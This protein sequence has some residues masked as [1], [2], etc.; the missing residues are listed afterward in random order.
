[1][2]EA[3]ITIVESVVEHFQKEKNAEIESYIMKAVAS[4]G[5]NVDKEALIKALNN[6][7]NQYNKGYNE[8]INDLAERLKKQSVL[9]GDEL[10]ITIEESELDGLVKE[11]TGEQHE[12]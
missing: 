12:N 11:L 6:D 9:V 2:Y 5:I 7:K 10:Y 3:P 4:Y 8:G 1:M